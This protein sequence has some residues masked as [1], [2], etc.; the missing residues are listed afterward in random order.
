MSSQN[1]PV[2]ESLTESGKSFIKMRKS[3]AAYRDPWGGPDFTVTNLDFTP[4]ILTH[5]FL[6]ERKSAIHGKTFLIL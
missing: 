6:K 2:K 5:C 3:K 1:T 4:S